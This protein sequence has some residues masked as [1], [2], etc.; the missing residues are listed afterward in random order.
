MSLRLIRVCELIK[1]ELGVIIGREMKFEAPRRHDVFTSLAFP[2]LHGKPACVWSR[3][4]LLH[5][6]IG[7]LDSPALRFV[8][9]RPNVFAEHACRAARTRAERISLPI[10]RGRPCFL[11]GCMRRVHPRERPARRGYR[12]ERVFVTLV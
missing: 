1:R 2:T 7:R 10:H 9:N 4:A 11:N 8:A 5:P 6:I 12:L 3:C